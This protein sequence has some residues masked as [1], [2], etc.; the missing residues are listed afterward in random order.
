[1]QG[2]VGACRPQVQGFG[3]AAPKVQGVRGAQPH[4]I[5]GSGGRSSS[6]CGASAGQQPPKEIPVY[7]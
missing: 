7:F 4:K 2:F 1:M 5:Q 6:G 3:G